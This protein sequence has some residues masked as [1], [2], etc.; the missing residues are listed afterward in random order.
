MSCMSHNI[1]RLFKCVF[2]WATIFASLGLSVSA[3]AAITAY[4]TYQTHSEYLTRGN[5]APGQ[6]MF[7]RSTTQ[8][9]AQTGNYAEVANNG[10]ARLNLNGNVTSSAVNLGST[11]GWFTTVY[12]NGNF[13]QAT[14]CTTSPITFFT[15][16]YLTDGQTINI[17]I[18]CTVPDSTPPTFQSAATSTDGTE[19]D[20]T[21]SEDIDYYGDGSDFTV[22]VNG[23]SLTSTGASF[24]GSVLTLTVNPAVTPGATVTLDFAD[25]GSMYDLAFNSPADFTNK[26][27]TNNAVSS[28]PTVTAGNI[29]IS[30]ASGTGGAYKIGDTITATWNNTAGGDNNAGVTGVTVD[31]SQFGGGAAVMATDSSGT[32]TATY[33]IV[34][35][36]IDATNRNVS[37][38]A[39]SASGST[40]T[41][42]TTNATLDNVAPTV[43]DNRISISGGSGTGGAYKIGDT[44]S[45]TWNNTSGG[46]NNSDS[47]SAVTV[48]FSAF[49]G[50]SAVTASNSSGTWTATYVISAGAIDATNRNISVSA[51]DNAGNT[52]TTPDT[53]NATVDNL[54]PTVT[55]GNISISGASGISGAYIA[56]DTVTAMWNNTAGGDNNSD[57]ISSVTVNFSSFGG[58]AA[59]T[60]LNNAGTWSATYILAAGSQE[61]SNNNVSVSVTD[62]AGNVR[63][64]A[65]TSNATVDTSIPSVSSVG[66]PSNATYLAG[67]NLDFTVNTNQNVTVDTTGGTPQIALTVGSTTR[68]AN[69]LSGSGGSTLQ[70]RYT[71]QAGDVDSDGITVAHLASTAVP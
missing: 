21:W 65:D 19:V 45:V 64:T 54:A 44:V 50:G 25:N 12:N 4:V 52:T 7:L 41:A 35:G 15:T 23:S 24:N 39:T 57:T 18:T 8:S 30:G 10:N 14:G 43:T 68:Y 16:Q 61:N 71:V 22:K 3:K 47:L 62:N 63:T 27:V 9:N 13:S 29:S 26:P 69:Y 28:G 48:D 20:V 2:L 56:G 5:P 40:T 53:S 46:D 70:F 59:V 11:A 31:F 1:S 67:Q 58:G 33:T 32:W 66:V 51:T 49:G 55:D 60:A 42:D 6:I 37:V 38:T 17:T 34:A 36:A